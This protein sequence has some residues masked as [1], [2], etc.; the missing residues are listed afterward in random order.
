MEKL[1]QL[2]FGYIQWFCKN[3]NLPVGCKADKSG[4]YF[5]RNDEKSSRYISR[6]KFEALKSAQIEYT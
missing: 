3:K 1:I 6:R 2:E 5:V 4:F